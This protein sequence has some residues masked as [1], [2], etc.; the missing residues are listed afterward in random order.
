MIQKFEEVKKAIIEQFG[1]EVVCAEYTNL[2]QPQ[3][4]V[5][6][7]NIK[8]VC[9]FL[10][11]DSRFFFDQ[12]S[13]LSA[14]DTGVEKSKI[15]VIYHLY[16]IPFDVIFV[17]K[18]ETER[19]DGVIEFAE[20]PSIVDVWRAA[21]W[22]EREAFDMFG[23]KFSGHPDLRRILLPADWEGFPLRKDYVEQEFYHGI[24]VAY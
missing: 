20:V 18:I 4:H 10:R 9:L 14:V 15:E 24:K 16:S 5:E 11:D 21:D 8:E 23:I 1:G 19:G 7:A 13:C 2:M 3:L 17:L 12:L 6:A 22:H